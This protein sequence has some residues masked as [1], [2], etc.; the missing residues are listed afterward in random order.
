MDFL[1]TLVFTIVFYLGSI[2]TVL[3][4]GIA[5]LLPPPAITITSRIW[6]TWFY[7]CTRWLLGIRLVIEGEVPQGPMLVAIKHQA[8]YEAN[9]TLYLFHNPAVVMKLE[10]LRIPVWGIA[11]KRHGSIFV[12]RAGTAVALR[13]MLREAEAAKAQGR[14]IVIFPE[15]TRTLPGTAPPLQSGFAGLYRMLKLPVVPVALD[16]G[17]VW[18]RR[19]FVKHAG[20]VT[21]RFGEVIPPGLPREEIEARVHAAINALN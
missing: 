7:W 15:G 8:A 6:G 4:A 5:I 18:P 14:P 20:T 17:T 10:L 11:A 2:P 13:R 21:M 3:A 9:L 19:R 1:R 12:D 16:S